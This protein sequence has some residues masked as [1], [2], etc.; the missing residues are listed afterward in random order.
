MRK[1]VRLLAL[2]FPLCIIPAMP[3]VAAHGE[4]EED[5]SFLREFLGGFDIMVASNFLHT[6]GAMLLLAGLVLLLAK[7]NQAD[8]YENMD[9]FVGG[10]S[11]N[12]L[13]YIALTF[14][15]LGGVMR[16]YEPGHPSLFDLSGNRWVSIMIAKHLLVIATTVCSII[17]TLESQDRKRRKLLAK[18]SLAFV[19][20]IGLLGAMANV[21][22]PE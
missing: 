22:G 10:R 11:A 2:L 17:A 4:G 5:I 9:G 18:L 15:L 3:L 13:I 7:L 8:F 19:V 12:R 21:V 1:R 20:I 6:V 16:L 14:N